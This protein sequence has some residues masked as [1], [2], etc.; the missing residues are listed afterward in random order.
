MLGFDSSL[1]RISAKS[2]LGWS[3]RVM[4]VTFIYWRAMGFGLELSA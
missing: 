3:L 2:F 1:S 4:S